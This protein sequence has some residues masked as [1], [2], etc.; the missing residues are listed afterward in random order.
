MATNALLIDQSAFEE[1]KALMI[2][3]IDNLEEKLSGTKQEKLWMTSQDVMSEYNISHSSLQKFRNT[4]TIPYHRHG[5]KI[6]YR[7]DE[8]TEFFS[9]SNK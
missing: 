3:K 9:S 6:L 4:S 2:K 1:F 8:L 5:G 7:R